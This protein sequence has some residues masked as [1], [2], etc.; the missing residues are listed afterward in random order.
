MSMNFQNSDA[1]VLTP[2]CFCTNKAWWS[3]SSIIFQ[4]FN[5]GIEG[6]E[7]AAP[8]GITRQAAALLAAFFIALTILL[9]LVFLLLCCLYPHGIC[10][11]RKALCCTKKTSAKKRPHISSKTNASEVNLTALDMKMPR[12]HMDSFSDVSGHQLATMSWTNAACQK[13][14][15]DGW[16]K[17]TNYSVGFRGHNTER[18]RSL[19]SLDDSCIINPQQW[20]SGSS[21]ASRLHSRSYNGILDSLNT[22]KGNNSSQE[23]SA[24]FGNSHKDKAVEMNENGF[25]DASTFQKD[26]S[27]LLSYNSQDLIPMCSTN[28]SREEVTLVNRGYDESAESAPC[29]WINKQFIFPMDEAASHVMLSAETDTNNSV[30]NTGAGIQRGTCNPI[31]TEISSTYNKRIIEETETVIN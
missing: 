18:I 8:T 10:Y 29:T 6:R 30:S 28:A 20:R 13:A 22:Q 14:D 3:I 15:L 24:R 21:T 27:N 23:M 26:Y 19:D 16:K 1:W 25:G 12:A 2:Y 5:D 7:V 9:F 4:D 31:I 11:S 17:D